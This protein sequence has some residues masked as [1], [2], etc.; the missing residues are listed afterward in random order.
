MIQDHETPTTLSI[1]IPHSPIEGRRLI[2]YVPTVAEFQFHTVRLK[3]L[4]AAKT[5]ATVTYFNSTQSD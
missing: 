5:I 4:N 2:Q 3:A 1:S